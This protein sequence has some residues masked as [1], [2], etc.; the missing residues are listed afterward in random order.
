MIFWRRKFKTKLFTIIMS[1]RAFHLVFY[2]GMFMNFLFTPITLE[3]PLRLFIL[4]PA[5]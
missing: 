5:V 2:P 4:V 3:S 1:F